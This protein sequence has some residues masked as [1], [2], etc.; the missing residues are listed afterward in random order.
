MT[1]GYVYIL[2]NQSMPGLL[3][4]G[5]TA[6]SVEQRAHELWQTGVPTPFEV[7]DE[8]FSP[9]CHELERELHDEFDEF[10]VSKSREFFAADRY[11][12]C[13]SLRMNLRRQV[14]DLVDEFMPDHTVSER[15]M[16]VE[17]A[18][19]HHLAMQLDA[20]PFEVVSSMEMLTGEELRPAL[21]RWRALV[22]ARGE[23]MKRGEPLP[24]F[25]P[26]TGATL[27]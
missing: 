24:E 21:E 25:K 22:K 13:N 4:I 10:R 7:V 15:D 12:V 23:A 5:R 16:A 17:E 14:E 8:V 27:Q 26:D 20:H 3:K 9:D 11:A 1:K 18:D 19:I 6:R 2:K